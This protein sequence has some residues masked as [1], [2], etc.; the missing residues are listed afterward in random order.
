MY[1]I[2]VEP[3]PPRLRNS[4]EVHLDYLKHIKES[5]ATF[6]EIVEEAKV[7]QIILWYLDSGCSKHM[8][9]DRSRLRNFVKRFIGTVRFGNDHFGAIIGQFCD[10]DMEVAFRKHSCYVCDT[11]GVELIKASKTKSWLWHRRLNYLNFGAINDHARKDLRRSW[12][13]IPTADIGIFVGYAPSRKGYRI[14]NKRTRHTMETIYVQF[15]ELSEPMAPMQLSTGPVPTFMTS[16]HIRLVPQPPSPTPN[17]SLTKNDCDTVFCPLFDEYFNPSPRVVS[18]VLAAV[19]APRAVDPAGSPSSTTIDQDVPSV[20]TSPTIQEIQYQVTHQ[21]S[22]S[23]ETTLQGFIPSNLHH[24]I[25]SFDTLVKLTKNH[26][27]ENVIG[28]PSRLV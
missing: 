9:G 11:D 8:I 21:Y 17:L 16:V 28:D 1:A 18:S 6:R 2:D 27:L 19:A 23:K 4:R 14:Y 26:P 5:V 10:S 7:V 12:Q 3:I 13:T 20:S 15:D 24:L 25:Q 22:S